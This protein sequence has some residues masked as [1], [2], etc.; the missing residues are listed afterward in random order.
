MLCQRCGER[1]ASVHFT[2]IINGEKNELYL[3]EKCAEELG[4]IS[5]QG[6]DPFSFPS[7]LAGILSPGLESSLKKTDNH[8]K[9]DE[10]GMTY[11][12][13]SQRGLLGCSDCYKNLEDR[14]EPLIKR[15]HGNNN[16]IGKVPK[17]K[18]GN[19]RLKREIRQLKEEMDK[20]VEKEDF[21]K[22]AEI[23]DKI[24]ELENEIGGE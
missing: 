3:C 10:C 14:L 1:E 18:G 15:I 9:C 20:A 6:S 12:D 8:I 22:A 11:E 2:K 4:H 24:H 19:L 23:R 16:H 17:R 13:F 21:E 5:L 7:L